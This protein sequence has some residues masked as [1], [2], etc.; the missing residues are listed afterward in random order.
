MAARELSKDE[1]ADPVAI[2][3]D[4]NE[5][6]TEDSVAS[7][8]I[9]PATAD[10]LTVDVRAE[11][12]DAAV[13][14]PANELKTDDKAA[15]GAVADGPD[16][17]ELEA[18]DTTGST[19]AVG[20]AL[21]EM[22][23]DERAELVAT[24]PTISELMMDDNAKSVE[25]AVVLLAIE[26]RIDASETADTFAEGLAT[27][28][29]NRDDISAGG[30][31]MPWIG[32]IAVVTEVAIPADMPT[33]IPFDGIVEGIGS[34]RDESIEAAAEG[35]PLIPATTTPEEAFER[36]TDV[37]AGEGAV[38]PKGPA[39]DCPFKIDEKLEASPPKANDTAED[40]AGAGV[41]VVCAPEGILSLSTSE[42]GVAL[43]AGAVVAPP[44][45]NNEETTEANED[46][47]EKATPPAATEV[48][49]IIGTELLDVVFD[50]T[51]IGMLTETLAVGKAPV[52]NPEAPVVS[53]T[54][55]LVYSVE[56]IG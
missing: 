7:V 11:L 40:T 18:A 10:E 21:I 53:T 23:M 46:K 13:G 8:S 30:I 39:R 2:G 4:I 19:V 24:G 55:S 54:T 17:K 12:A 28:E 49:V 20:F 25:A 3:L 41:V 37:I 16:V 35:T 50:E 34:R 38:R 6:R 26:L 56:S 31:F 43:A 32:D 15:A 45:P 1:I 33:G 44:P 48:G 42:P 5:L 51:G 22:S 29:R 52:E 47:R 9:G 14:L 36:G 27:K